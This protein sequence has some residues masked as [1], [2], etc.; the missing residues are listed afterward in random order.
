MNRKNFQNLMEQAEKM[1]RNLE[2]EMEKLLVESGSGGGMVNVAMN[3]TKQLLSVTIDPQAVDQE[4]VEMLQDLIV[5]AVNE[6][7]R[8]VDE[9]LSSQLGGLPSLLGSS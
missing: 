3:G 9:A 1:K 5:A 7:G 8:K 4:D 6:A 2:V